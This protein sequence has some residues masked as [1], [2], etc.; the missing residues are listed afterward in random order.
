MKIFKIFFL[1]IFLF[2]KI[3]NV[4]SQQQRTD[5]VFHALVLTERGGIHEGFVVAALE[6]LNQFS[7]EQ[8]FDFHVINNTDSICSAYLSQYQLFIQLNFPPYMWSDSS[9]E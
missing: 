6:W 4:F 3:S 1:S 2:M 8:H 7:L 9:K 5:P